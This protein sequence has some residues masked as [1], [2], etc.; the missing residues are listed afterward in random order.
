VRKGVAFDIKKE[1]FENERLRLETKKIRLTIEQER[2]ASGRLNQEQNRALRALETKG[3][4]DAPA[5]QTQLLLK[6]IEK[7][8]K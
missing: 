2:L 1:T 7:L 8:D 4:S 5:L 6:L 3:R